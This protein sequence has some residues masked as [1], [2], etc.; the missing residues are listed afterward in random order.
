M[1]N[2]DFF[3]KHHGFHMFTYH[4]QSG[5]IGFTWAMVVIMIVEA[6]GVSYLLYNWNPF[7]HWLHLAFSISV[8]VFLLADL[9]AV[10]KNPIMVI[11]HELTIKVG[12][13]PRISLDTSNIKEIRCGKLNYENDRK[14]KDVLDLSL[15][16]FEEPAF[17]LVLTKPLKRKSIL[18][19]ERDIS[20]VFFS[21]DDK[22]Q[23]RTLISNKLE[24]T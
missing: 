1:K 21:V 6:A 14:S 2:E 19:G 9:N 4:I 18:G 20:R 10:K 17:E 13:R 15:M 16:G 7:L 12:I 23:F 8:V 24:I 5:Y 22:D 11:E 3:P